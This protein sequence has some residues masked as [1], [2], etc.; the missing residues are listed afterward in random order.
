MNLTIVSIR[1]AKSELFSQPI[2][3]AS[4]GV[5]LRSFADQIN[6]DEPNNQ[7]YKHPS[8]FALYEIGKFDDNTGTIEAHKIPKLL[9]QAD[10]LKTEKPLLDRKRIAA[11]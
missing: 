2:F 7:L 11:V 3:V 10:Q 4:P 5:A 8:D 1:D 9:I 6:T